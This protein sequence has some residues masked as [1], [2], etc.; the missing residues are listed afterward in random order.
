[1]EVKLNVEEGKKR[2]DLL[3]RKEIFLNNITLTLGIKFF[4]LF[5]N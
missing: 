5:C 4:I 1:M 2:R 3:E